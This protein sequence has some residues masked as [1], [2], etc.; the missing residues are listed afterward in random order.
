MHEEKCKA[1]PLNE[2]VMNK[3][4]QKDLDK[5]LHEQVDQKEQSSTKMWD[6]PVEQQKKEQEKITKVEVNM[7]EEQTSKTEEDYQCGECGHTFKRLT[8][9]CSNCGCQFEE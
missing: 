9:Y 5:G 8:K 4:G 6:K 7:D 1:N 2:Q 3:S